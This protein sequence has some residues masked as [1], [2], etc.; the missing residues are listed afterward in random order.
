M[1][2]AVADEHEVV[3]VV[4]QPDRPA[5]RGHKLVATPVK[6][7]AQARGLRV[8]T[9]EK[10]RPFADEARALRAGA[11]VV[12]S[13]GKIVPQTLLDAVPVAFNVHPSLLPLYRGATP[14]QSA[15]RDG[16]DETGV[17]IIAMDAGMDTGDVLLQE[18]TPIG[19]TETYGELHD[20]LAKRGAELVVEAL[21]QHADGTLKRKPQSEV[22]RELGIT[23]DEI[24]RTLTRPLRKE[25]LEIAWSQPARRIVDQ[26]RSL[27]PAPA[28]RTTAPVPA[29]PSAA[30]TGGEVAPESIKVLAAHVGG[31]SDAGGWT[32]TPGGVNIASGRVPTTFGRAGDG[33]VV[34]LDLVVPPGRPAMS[35]EAYARSVSQ[36]LARMFG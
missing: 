22:A 14:L 4:T 20:R 2:E 32:M 6:R 30:L 23:E 29:T 35:G 9:P 17:T 7:A 1:L 10:L 34:V 36:R 27:A 21:R 28:A 33:G 16:R 11:F 8:L 13:Y 31:D 19:P 25:D 18:R 24:A 15:I 12:A 5:G 26:V 3:S